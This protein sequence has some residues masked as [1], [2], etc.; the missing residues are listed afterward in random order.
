[1]MAHSTVA[2]IFFSVEWPE[3]LATATRRDGT[4]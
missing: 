3:A 2:A 4:L 1:M